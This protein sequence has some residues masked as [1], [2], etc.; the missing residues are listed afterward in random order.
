MS[1]HGIGFIWFPVRAGG[2]DPG[3]VDS[4]QQRVA[5]LREKG[6]APAPP[7]GGFPRVAGQFAYDPEAVNRYVAELAAEG[8]VMSPPSR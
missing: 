1:G 8:S 3:S 5:D 7:P 2:Y 4:Y 6:F